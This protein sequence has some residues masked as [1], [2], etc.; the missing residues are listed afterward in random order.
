MLTGVGGLFG[1]SFFEQAPANR[2]RLENNNRQYL[3][4]MVL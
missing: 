3:V 2:R 4:L 1:G